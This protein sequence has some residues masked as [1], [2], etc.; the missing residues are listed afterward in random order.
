MSSAIAELIRSQ[1]GGAAD[2]TGIVKL[3]EITKGFLHIDSTSQIPQFLVD[4][5]Q[6][7]QQSQFGSYPDHKDIAPSG[8]FL[9]IFVIIAIAH[10][11]L[12][13]INYMRGHRFWLS[14]GFCF[15]ATM[16]WIGFALRI[17]WAKNILKL[18][19]GIASEVLLVLPIVFLASFNLVLA[20]RIFTWKHPVFGNT[21]IFWY[22]MLAI[23]SVV[24]AVV[25]MT[26]VAGVVPYLYFLSRSHY[27]MCRNVVKVTSILI[28]LYSLLSIAFVIM[29]YIVPTSQSDKDALVYQ[30]F[31]IKSFSP[32]YFPVKNAQSE[33]EDIFVQRYQN[34]AREPKR[35]IVGGGLDLSELNEND[36][37]AELNEF[38]QAG[39]QKFSLKHNI[40]VTIITITS[41][42]VFIGAL[43]RCIACFIDDTFASQSW[44]YDPV[45]MYVLWGA[46]ETI[47]NI[48][49]LV[50]RIDLRFYRPDN[51]KK[52]NREIILSASKTANSDYPEAKEAD[53][54]SSNQS[55]QT[56]V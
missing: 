49:Y 39:E 1:T 28:T 17:V 21:K 29:T 11:S 35:T 14:L 23:Y 13:T 54:V 30:P 38:E 19:V 50:G 36:E 31:W 53:L 3:L 43:F 2:G 26:I 55:S 18:H 48:L 8:L 22:A 4:Y 37:V 34:D 47:C 32:F 12:F 7:Q 51:F 56:R 6:D 27:D 42:F 41:V 9:A 16:R 46:L 24:I 52:E 25:T 15:Y 10:G 5:V 33:G 20:Q 40:S 44:I 45:V